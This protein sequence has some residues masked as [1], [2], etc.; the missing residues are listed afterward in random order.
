MAPKSRDLHFMNALAEASF[1]VREMSKPC[2]PGDK[3]YLAVERAYSLIMRRAKA[4]A[5][6]EYLRKWT[7]NRAYELWKAKKTCVVSADELRELRAVAR[8]QE[9]EEAERGEFAKLIERIAVL[10]HRLAAIDPEFHSEAVAALRAATHG[11]G[12]S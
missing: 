4:D 12:R 1:L 9:Q 2:P 7:L 3:V 5:G 10:E 6:F 11:E 8:I